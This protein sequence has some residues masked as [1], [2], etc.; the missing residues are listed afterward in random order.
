[1][2]DVTADEAPATAEVPERSPWERFLF[3]PT[4][5]SAMALIRLGFG[6]TCIVWAVSLL[7]DIDPFLSD[8][9]LRYPDNLAKGSWNIL[10][11]VEWRQ[12]PLVACLIM[13]V[14]GFTT[15]VG[16]RTRL[17]TAVAA[18]GMLSLQRTA[19]L[20]FNSGDLL[21]RQVGI[22]LALAPAGLVLSVDA[23]RARRSGNTDPP[24]LRAPF[25]QRFLQMNLALG[26]LLSAWAKARGSTWHD[27]T[28][29]T[30]ALRI[31]DVQRFGPPEW[32]L[33][34]DDLLN[35]LTWGTLA[36]EASFIFL[37]WNRK[38]R[39]WVLLVGLF[40]HLGIDLMFDVGFF[41]PGLF[42]SYIAFLPPGASDRWAAAIESWL[43]RF[44]RF[45]AEATADPPPPPP[46]PGAPDAAPA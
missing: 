4:T 43:G 17:S 10:D 15:M 45:P 16:Y 30:R 42:L 12:A 39:P 22:G 11:V 27:G 20:V 1:V 29:V 18:L 37:V 24:A 23:A 31:I 19:P 46:P 40:L 35:L 14:A 21:L 3:E 26:Y 41:T 13:I 32:F 8:G 34:Q 5:T 28:A 9:A 36:F 33:R 2:S 7:P 44:R 38:A 25:A 6:A